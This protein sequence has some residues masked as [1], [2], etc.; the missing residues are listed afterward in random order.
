M[1]GLMR[2]LVAALVVFVL[3]SAAGY[4]WASLN[5]SFSQSEHHHYI[6]EI[7]GVQ[8]EAISRRLSRSLSATQVLAM[9]LRRQGGH[10]ESFERYAQELISTFG[11]ISNLQLAPQGVVS[12]IFPL[13]GNEKALGHNILRDDRRRADAFRAINERRL[14]IAGP[15]ELVQGGVAVIGR[16]PVFMSDDYDVEQFWGFASALIFV[17][18]LLSVTDLLELEQRGYRFEL[19]HKNPDNL[20][21]E[22]FARST[23]PLEGDVVSMVIPVPNGSWELKLANVPEIDPQSAMVQAVGIS[24]AIAF[25]LSALVFHMM[26]EPERLRELVRQKTEALEHMAFYDELTGLANRSLMRTQIEQVLRLVRRKRIG[27]GLIY[28]DLDDFK[29]IN[30]AFGHETGDRMLQQVAERMKDE[31]RDS[32]LV[33][34]FGG[35]EFAV[36]LQDIDT[37]AQ[38][39]KVAEKLLRTLHEPYLLAGKELVV[40]V[41]LGIVLLPQ[42]GD[43]LS[44]VMRNADLALYAS[45][46]EGKGRFTFFNSEMQLQ[47]MRNMLLEQQLRSAIP[48]NELRLH[49]QPV[50][51]IRSGSVRGFEALIRWH[52]PHDGLLSPIMFIGQAE[53]T[54]MIVEL[55]YWVLEETARFLN[56]R[57]QAGLAPLPVAVNVSARQ[58]HDADFSRRVASIIRQSGL[59][60][61]LFEL[62]IT[63]SMLMENLD[64][65]SAIIADLRES[66]ISFSIDDF[67]TGYSSFSQLRRLPFDKLKIDRS[68][69]IGLAENNSDVQIA[70]AIIAV[71]REL[72][73]KVIAEGVETE[74]QRALLVQ[75]GC[76]FAQGYLFS[77]PVAEE[78]VVTFP[79]RLPATD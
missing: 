33:S 50:V 12:T 19:L 5:R 79:E 59:D 64:E 11:G 45:K 67:G 26:S 41:S 43:E 51:D 25:V 71:A 60:A 27:A 54:G 66:G 49:Y 72:D 42:D 20:K 46:R 47:A 7:A 36:L 4:Y 6:S 52:H 57:K 68:F 17:D 74:A 39:V 32:D 76:D 62:E 75:H 65:A 69:V 31:L 34:R 28:M 14:T 38:A 18:D 70:A 9:E 63:E 58:L 22:V 77:K 55:G 40:N 1:Y 30:D 16:N 44:T 21:M 24:L 37:P 56:R 78:I 8:A 29:R 73:M 15:F 35:D 61:A 48:N 53:Q 23:A 10:I 13:A 2:S 3:A